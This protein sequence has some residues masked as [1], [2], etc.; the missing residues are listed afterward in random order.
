MSRPETRERGGGFDDEPT[1]VRAQS[2]RVDPAQTLPGPTWRRLAN[3]RIYCALGAAGGE[4][5]TAEEAA[6]QLMRR[7]PAARRWFGGV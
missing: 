3:G 1:R 5:A 2:L 6:L 4:G 7:L